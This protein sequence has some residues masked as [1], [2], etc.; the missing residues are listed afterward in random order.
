MQKIRWELNPALLKNETAA[1]LA[2]AAVTMTCRAIS[3]HAEREKVLGIDHRQNDTI[4]PKLLRLDGRGLVY[5][6]GLAA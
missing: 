6:T 2:L 4:L 3:D 1:L 5:S